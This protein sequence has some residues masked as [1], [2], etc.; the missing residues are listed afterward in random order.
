MNSQSICQG[1]SLVEVNH[2]HEGSKVSGL[3][4]S[5]PCPVPQ[6]WCFWQLEAF[7]HYLWLSGIPSFLPCPAS[8]PVS[9]VFGRWAFPCPCWV[10]LTELWL[11]SLSF[12]LICF[13][14]DLLASG[15]CNGSF[16]SCTCLSSFQWCLGERREMDEPG[17]PYRTSG[18]CNIPGDPDAGASTWL[19]HRPPEAKVAL[20][21]CWMRVRRALAQSSHLTPSSPPATPLG[22]TALPHW[23]KR[24]SDLTPLQ[25]QGQTTTYIRVFPSQLSPHELPLPLTSNQRD[26]VQFL[27]RSVSLGARPLFETPLSHTFD[28]VGT[29][30]SFLYTF[31]AQLRT[32]DAIKHSFDF[33][34][35]P[36]PY[37]QL[38]SPWRE[39]LNLC[40]L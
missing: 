22:L 20:R 21:R 26:R 35:L 7:T 23:L 9:W 14:S 1:W 32:R 24:F 36:R 8:V 31:T 25:D 27:E 18:V 29:D 17:L 3:V 12:L 4:A 40:C 11:D 6:L 34:P 39:G 16:L 13:S 19:S 33:L 2:A 37:P 28:T 10:R 30:C 5:V 38:W 15:C